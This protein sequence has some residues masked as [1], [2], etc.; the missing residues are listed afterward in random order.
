MN[1]ELEIEVIKK[2]KL[3]VEN[4][5][6]CKPKHVMAFFYTTMTTIYRDNDIDALKRFLFCSFRLVSFT[7]SLLMAFSKFIALFLIYKQ[8]YM[9]RASSGVFLP[10]MIKPKSI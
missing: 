5:T 7:V 8:F 10:F 4:K 2:Y 6:F 9:I 3:E 1:F